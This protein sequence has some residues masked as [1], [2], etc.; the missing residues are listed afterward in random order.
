MA[1]QPPEAREG[2]CHLL[3]NLSTLCRP[4]QTPLQRRA[5]VVMFD[6]QLVQP[7]AGRRSS[8]PRLGLVG[9][10]EEVLGMPT[11][12]RVELSARC[13]LFKCEFANGLEHADAHLA[14][15][16]RQ[17]SQQVSGDQ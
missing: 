6:L 15:A 5:E 16:C 2:A 1:G 14:R 3:R 10:L 11:L 7:R 13:Q 17:A 9:E 8:E 12:S 4:G